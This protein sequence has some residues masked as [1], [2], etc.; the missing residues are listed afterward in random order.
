MISGGHT[1]ESVFVC[2]S[3]LYYFDG[4]GNDGVY[5]CVVFLHVAL[6]KLE[7]RAL[8][9]L[10]QFIYVHRSVECFCLYDAGEGD[11]LACEEFLRHDAGMVLDVGRRSHVGCQFGDVYRSARL[12][13]VA[14]TFQFVGDGE[15]VHRF[16]CHAQASDGFIYELVALFV[17]TF[18]I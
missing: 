14:V 1:G 16:F 6:R 3:L 15:D 5:L 13:Y 8:G 4:I 7:E 9:F 2:C 11:E 10:H 18:G 17:E 12:L